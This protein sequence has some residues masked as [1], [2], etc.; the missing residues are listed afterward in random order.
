MP[1][2]LGLAVALFRDDAA[3]EVFARVPHRGCI[4]GTGIDRGTRFQRRAGAVHAFPPGPAAV[5]PRLLLFLDT[6]APS[7][8][9]PLSSPAITGGGAPARQS[10]VH[11]ELS[12]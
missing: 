1:T 5:A 7:A 3:S 10:P 11:P 6:T 12:N 9:T 8:C 2:S 4:A